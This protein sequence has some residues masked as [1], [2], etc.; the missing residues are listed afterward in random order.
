MADLDTGSDGDGEVFLDAPGGGDDE[1]AQDEDEGRVRQD[2]ADARA[3]VAVGV[4]AVLGVAVIRDHP[5]AGASQGLA[6]LL[7]GAVDPVG[8]G[9]ARAVA[10]L[11][12]EPGGDMHPG[13][14]LP[15]DQLGDAVDRAGDDAQGEQRDHHVE[16]D[17]CEDVEEAQRV[18]GR[19]HL[20]ERGAPGIEERLLGPRVGQDLLR[21]LRQERA[22]EGV[23]GEQEDDR[24]AEGLGVEEPVEPQEQL[25]DRHIPLTTA[26]IGRG[27]L[28][29]ALRALRARGGLGFL[30]CHG[31]LLI[32]GCSRGRRAAPAG[33]WPS[34]P[35]RR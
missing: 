3:R 5:P 14:L 15:L 25:D 24:Q 2:G 10:G 9:D 17:G 7:Q 22:D 4:E 32:V 26:D 34:A 12:E 33:P 6:G 8:A 21:R 19:R 31:V 35:R 16:A 30:V 29:R 27:D 28:G 11:V 20:A 18:E 23:D 13:L 1:R